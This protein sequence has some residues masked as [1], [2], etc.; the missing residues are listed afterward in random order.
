MLSALQAIEAEET[1]TVVLQELLPDIFCKVMDFQA[2]ANRKFVEN[3]TSFHGYYNIIKQMTQSSKVIL[4]LVR[5]R[6]QAGGLG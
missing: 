5:G 4:F 3:K 6:V 2:I 1:V